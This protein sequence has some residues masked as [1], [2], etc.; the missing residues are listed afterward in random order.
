MRIF[1]AVNPMCLISHVAFIHRGAAIC[2]PESRLTEISCFFKCLYLLR[3]GLSPGKFSHLPHLQKK[4]SI[5]TMEQARP[6]IIRLLNTSQDI[7]RL[8]SSQ[9]GHE[10]R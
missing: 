9:F 6:D 4:I 10:L 1:Q 7:A 2:A 8:T 5:Q 3:V